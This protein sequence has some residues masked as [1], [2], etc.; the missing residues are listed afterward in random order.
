MKDIKAVLSA[1]KTTKTKK[2]VTADDRDKNDDDNNKKEDDSVI[3]T[4]LARAAKEYKN[5]GHNEKTKKFWKG[6]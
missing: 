1:S 3:E 6:R 5:K 2:A 4:V